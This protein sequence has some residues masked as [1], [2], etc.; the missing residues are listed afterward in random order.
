MGVAPGRGGASLMLEQRKSP[1]PQQFFKWKPLVPTGG[2]SIR[3]EWAIH[4]D[5]YRFKRYNGF[6]ETETI[7]IHCNFLVVESEST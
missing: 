7:E 1:P 2:T 3:Y 4:T 5:S 6:E